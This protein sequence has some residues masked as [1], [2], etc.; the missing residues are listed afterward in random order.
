ME[1]ATVAAEPS[2]DQPSGL[3]ALVPALVD[4]VPTRTPEPTA[5]PDALAE[6][7]AEIL[8]ETGLSGRTLLWLR[9]ADWINLAISLLYVLI[10]FVVGTWLI[11]WLFPR[12]VRRTQTVLDDRLLQAS[13]TEL[14]WL[15]VVIRCW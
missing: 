12:L 10:A 8:R 14:R 7:V 3:E 13:G 5:T 4:I 11:R 15:A 9:Y 2:G 6:G 1:T